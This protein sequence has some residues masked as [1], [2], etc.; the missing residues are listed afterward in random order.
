MHLRH[1]TNAVNRKRKIVRPTIIAL[2]YYKLKEKI[3]KRGG[4]EVRL[5]SGMSSRTGHL[6][7]KIKDDKV[8]GLST[9]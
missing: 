4:R 1:F 9:L 7:S 2:K 3:L 8:K 5:V 6:L